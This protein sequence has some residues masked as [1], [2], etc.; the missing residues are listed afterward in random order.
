MSKIII[1][2]E[3]ELECLLRRVLIEVLQ[4]LFV[5]DNAPVNE[6]MSIK[7]A[8]EF[9]H[10]SIQTIY[11]KTCPRKIPHFKRGKKL[12]FK[13]DE[14]LEWLT[15]DKRKTTDEIIREW[16]K[17]REHNGRRGKQVINN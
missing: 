2:T 7:Q 10:I 13:R 14:L 3:E 1:T 6:I 16:E 11:G 8:S 9:L 4:P 15:Q 5:K 12:Y 17:K